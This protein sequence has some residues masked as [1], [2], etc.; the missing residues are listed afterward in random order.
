MNIF[1]LNVQTQRYTME[2]PATYHAT[3]IFHWRVLQLSRVTKL[4]TMVYLLVPGYG[5]RKTC[6]TA[7]V[8]LIT[9]YI[10]G[11]E[12]FVIII[13]NTNLSHITRK[14][15]FGIFDQVRLK[16]ACSATETS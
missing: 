3:T 5:N 9:Y 1:V 10:S 16:P 11:H 8:C 6:H 2:F 12:V 7:K 4:S 14:P 13:G 15:D